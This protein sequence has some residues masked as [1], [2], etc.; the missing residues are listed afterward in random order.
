[1]S[2][3][4]VSNSSSG[5]D[6]SA[7][8]SQNIDNTPDVT[9]QAESKQAA[10]QQGKSI[11]PQSSPVDEISRIEQV[12][13]RSLEIVNASFSVDRV[14]DMVRELEAALPKASNSLSF[15]VDDVLNR[16]VITVVDKNSGEVVR[17]LPSD[18]VVRVM[19]NIDKMRGILFED[20]S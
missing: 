12:E 1:M 18:E 14:R 17:T 10:G 7:G 15:R 5:F 9:H 3:I 16:P 11:E 20:Q 19:H 8:R 6:S 2:D 4:N 13:G